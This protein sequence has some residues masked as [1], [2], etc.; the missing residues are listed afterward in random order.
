MQFNFSKEIFIIQKK[1]KRFMGVK[2]STT[3]TSQLFVLFGF[4]YYISL[5]TFHCMQMMWSKNDVKKKECFFV[6]S[7]KVQNLFVIV[8]G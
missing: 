3:C 6:S 8:S 4:N 7:L 2:F 5:R 1:Q